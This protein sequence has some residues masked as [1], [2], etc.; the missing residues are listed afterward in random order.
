MLQHSRLQ[1]IL[2]GSIFRLSHN[3][4]M[5]SH[6]NLTLVT[7]NGMVTTDGGVRFFFSIINIQN[8][9]IIS[10]ASYIFINVIFLL[11]WNGLCHR[12]SRKK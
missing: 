6:K 12:S 2:G 7:G 3:S 11:Q 8:I 9:A 10:H 4:N 1:H 5:L